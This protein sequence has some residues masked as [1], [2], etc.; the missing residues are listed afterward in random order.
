MMTALLNFKDIC[1][2]YFNAFSLDAKLFLPIMVTVNL[3]RNILK[4]YTNF[5]ACRGG[6]QDGSEPINWVSHRDGV[7]GV[8]IWG[9][10][11]RFR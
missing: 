4:S 1:L 9:I 11:S 2:Q 3:D 5:V 6:V 7:L 10:S 8:T